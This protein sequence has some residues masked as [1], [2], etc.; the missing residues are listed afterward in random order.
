MTTAIVCSSILAAMIFVLGFNVS[1]NRG[2]A[3]QRG[4]SQMPT[5]PADPLLIA[6]RAHGNATEY[7]P[8]LIAL[9]LLVGWT[10]PEPWALGL[11]VAATASRLLHAYAML[12]SETLAKENNPRLAGAM[13]T[14]LF[15]T[16]L[17][18]TAAVGAF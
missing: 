8:T 10:M 2:L 18:V 16:A 12:R 3:A 6:Q 15:G 5:D 14:Y 4:G 13:G 7:V 11:V 17:A 9:F 1:R